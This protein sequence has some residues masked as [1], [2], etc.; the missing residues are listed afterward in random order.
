VG[1]LERIAS[2]VLMIAAPAIFIA[3]FSVLGARYDYPEILRSDPSVIFAMV[4][5]GGDEFIAL[6][7][8]MFAASLLFIPIAVLLRR[9]MAERSAAADL[10]MAFG[11]LAGLVQAMGFLRWIILNPALASAYADPAAN[12]STRETIASVFAAFH[13]YL[14]VGVGEHLGYFF[15]GLWTI[16]VAIGLKGRSILLRLLGAAFALGIFAGMAEPFGVAWAGAVNA[17]AYTLWAVWL[18]VLGAVITIT[19]SRPPSPRSLPQ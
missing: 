11:A 18:I 7:Y 6:W 16:F 4:V 8:L 17:I 5:R 3:A 14:G 12:E 13:M 2:G 9:Q 19:R 10:S 15:T 1:K